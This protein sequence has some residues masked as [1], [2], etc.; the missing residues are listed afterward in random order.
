MLPR[1]H[2]RKK[3]V[4]LRTS[5]YT[6]TN[7]GRYNAKSMRRSLA[8]SFILAAALGAANFPEPVES[9]WTAKNFRFT[10]GEVLP[11]L[12]LHYS[13]IGKPVRDDNGTVRNAV[14]IMHGTTG[15]G[16]GFL[17]EQFGGHLFG[18][19]Q[20]LDATKYYIILPDAVGHGKSSKPSDGLHMRFPK[21]TYDDMVRADYLL[22]TEALGVNHLRLV[23]GTSMGAMHTWVWGEMY[24]D[25]MDA[26]MPLA[27]Q[28]V[29]IAGRNRMLRKMIVNA[30]EQDPEW[31]D[32]E[33]SKP[34]VHGLTAAM[35]V[36]SIMTSSPLQL[37]KRFPTRESA[38]ENLG[39]TIDE[40][41][42]RQDANDMIYAYESSRFYNPEPNLGKIKAPLLAINSADDQVNPPELG[43]G[44]REIKK[45]KR[46]RFILIPIGDATRGHG[47]HSIPA[48]WGKH[49]AEL[50]AE[51]ALGNPKD[52]VWTI[53]APDA[54]RVKIET[55]KGNFVLEVTRALAPC[56]ADRFYHLVQ[57]G[58]YNGS[59]FYR[60]IANRFAQFGI[61]GDPAVANVWRDERFPD[62][63][64]RASNLRGSFAFANTGK[65]A[66][67]TQ[68]Y[69]NTGDQSRLDADG[70][71]PLGKV[72]E[73]MDVVDRLYSGYGERSGGGMRAGHQ[74]KL[75][76]EGNAWPDR[77]FPLVDKLLIA[78]VL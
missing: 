74:Q 41:V 13:T 16:K 31:S 35:Y 65:D 61:A 14:L 78:T 57:S 49:L 8:L 75:F 5:A 64:V 72:V 3:Y 21:Y 59:R 51:S 39:K 10:T 52:P 44:E 30:I 53:P 34:P 25:F 12:R 1:M 15:S 60:V 18:P 71:A 7:T 55:T 29:E 33:Y 9:D 56:G 73:G 48:I 26:L 43:I 47:T 40:R 32:G 67:T 69:I 45:V 46:G 20:L 19:G 42:T 62:D 58:F 36:M 27:S 23:M 68:I 37:Q 70:F 54:Y 11:E 24:P 76:A 38:D 17:S 22:L 77:E 2:K 28:P 66:R 6:T 4:A 50:L 63:P